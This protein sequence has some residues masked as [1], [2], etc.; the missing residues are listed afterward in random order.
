LLRSID[1]LQVDGLVLVGT[2]WVLKILVHPSQWRPM[3]TH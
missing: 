1:D 3:T 2:S